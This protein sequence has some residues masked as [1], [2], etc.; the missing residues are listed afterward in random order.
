MDLRYQNQHCEMSLREGVE[1][2][3]AYL[4]SNGSH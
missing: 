2:Y 3:H 1:E 4:E